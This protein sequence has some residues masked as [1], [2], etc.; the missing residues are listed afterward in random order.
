[1]EHLNIETSLGSIAA[2][3][4]S[5]SRVFLEHD[6]DFCC[7]G[8]RSLQDAC[9]QQKISPDAIMHEIEDAQFGGDGEGKNWNEEP[10]ESIVEHIINRYH[11]R[12]RKELP[13]INFLAEKVLNAH[14][15]RHPEELTNLKSTIS[16]LSEDLIEHM[17]KEETVLFP[18]IIDG[19]AR[20]SGQ[21]VR[22]L[23]KEHE[24]A[25]VFL[26]RIKEL[27]DRF[28]TPSDACPTWE[29]YYANLKQLDEEMRMH[30]HL[31]NNVLF[32]RALA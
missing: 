30:I 20:S 21:T 9:L 27:S 11:N 13:H 17:E 8:N 12:L 31:E 2:Q 1:M 15:E 29:A 4:P 23:Q 14:G 16:R 6:I 5:A 22:V 24:A 26:E 3:I 28:T 18:W 19:N 7:G 25:A 32:P 10:L